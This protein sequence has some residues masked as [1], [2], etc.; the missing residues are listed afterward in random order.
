MKAITTEEFI[1]RA[2]LIHNNKYDYSHS[3]YMNALSKI[4]IVCSEHGEFNQNSYSHLR[5]CGCSKCSQRY[6]NIDYFKTKASIRHNDKYDYSLVEFITTEHKIKIIC[7]THGIFEQKMNNHLM[8][9]GCP[10]CWKLKRNN[11]SFIQEAKLIHGNIYDYSELNYAGSTQ[12][13]II[14]C[15]EHGNFEQVATT[16]LRGGGCPKCAIKQRNFNLKYSTDQFIIISKKLHGDKYD[17]SLVDYEYNTDKVTIICPKHG[18]FEQKPNI[19]LQ[20]SGCPMCKQS[21]GEEKITQFLTKNNVKFIYQKGFDDCRNVNRLF[22]DFYL[23]DS[24]M[25]IE[26]DGKQHYEINEYFGGIKSFIELQKRDEIKNE[27]CLNNNIKLH[28]IR[29]DD[30][31]EEKLNEVFK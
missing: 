13:V 3:I 25:C 11:D 7:H 8:G 5:G 2:N 28:R 6:M 18:K 21:R 19:H 29:Y 1:E 24:N 30:N 20:G 22:F 4:I 16:H 12:T 26:F 9:N 17:Y 14:G 27:Y 31:I 10:E 15:K 23:P